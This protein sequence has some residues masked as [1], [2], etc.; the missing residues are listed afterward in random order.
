MNHGYGSSFAQQGPRSTTAIAVPA[1]MQSH[2][3]MYN[4]PR[5][6]EVYTLPDT[7][8]E[9]FSQDVLNQFQKDA[10]GRILFFTAPPLDRAHNGFSRNSSGLGH[11]AKYL[12]G[13]DEWLTTRELKRKA[14]DTQ[15]LKRPRPKASAEDSHGEA[16]TDGAMHQAAEALG[17]W[18]QAFESE[19][20]KW[21]KDTGLE[22]WRGSVRG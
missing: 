13:R 4:P 2:G 8:H 10:A 17:K 22:G 6:P 12:D 14:R 21:Q 18:F 15:S 5:P 20:N 9:A 19:T 16:P 1:N 11:S 3:T 7:V